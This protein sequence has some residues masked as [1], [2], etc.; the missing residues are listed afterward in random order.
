MTIGK[1]PLNFTFSGA[2]S[3]NWLF[4]NII[5]YYR[6]K[7]KERKKPLSLIVDTVIYYCKQFDNR[8]RF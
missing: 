6:T 1:I 5:D 2:I 8:R 4:S 7:N 3:C